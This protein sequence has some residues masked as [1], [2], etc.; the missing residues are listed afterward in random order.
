MRHRYKNWRFN[1]CTE[2]LTK[3]AD[4]HW[5]N[6]NTNIAHVIVACT[7]RMIKDGNG[8]PYALVIEDENAHKSDTPEGNEYY[9]ELWRSILQKIHDGF[10]E[11][12]D[13]DAWSDTTETC[14]EALRLLVRYYHNLWD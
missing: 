1:R 9:M 12:L 6:L 8:F 3:A 13:L 14:D 2:K 5:Y 11:S 7:D 4:R 10:K